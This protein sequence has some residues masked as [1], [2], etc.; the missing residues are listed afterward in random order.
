MGAHEN[1]GV[2]SDAQ[3][4]IAP[5]YSSNFID[6]GITTPQIGVGQNAPYL[7]IRTAV[8]PTE[9]ADTLSIEVRCSATNSGTT[10]NGTIK[11]IFMPLA[12]AAGAEV[13]ASDAKLATAGA[14]IYRGQLPYEVDLRYIQLYFNNTVTN[15]TFTI[16]AW[17]SD[18]P[19]SDFGKQVLSSPVGNP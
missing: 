18:G 5:A 15:G 4:V 8:A 10:L 17:L 9:V 19:A 11:Y 16:D 14:W 12:G 1:L 13:L 2:F 7:C 3:A 6:L